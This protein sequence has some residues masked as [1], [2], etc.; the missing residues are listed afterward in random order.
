MLSH[1]DV[2]FFLGLI[3]ISTWFF[4][5]VLDIFP[6]FQMSMRKKNKHAKLIF[7]E[8]RVHLYSNQIINLCNSFQPVGSN[9]NL[10]MH[11]LSVVCW[12]DILCM[13]WLN[14]H[15]PSH[16]RSLMISSEYSRYVFSWCGLLNFVILM[17]IFTFICV[18]AK[19]IH[20]CISHFFQVFTRLSV[21]L[22]VCLIK[23]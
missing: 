17:E 11:F 21:F 9:C 10:S 6:L 16:W 12:L 3:V 7:T 22:S 8:L 2:M 19:N 1:F 23:I 5:S 15:S 18:L 14:I 20:F 13:S 4:P